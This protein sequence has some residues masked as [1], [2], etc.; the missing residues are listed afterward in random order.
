LESKGTTL[1]S[2][3]TA[4]PA[5]MILPK[6]PEFDQTSGIRSLIFLEMSK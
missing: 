4:F 6:L 5:I 3:E 2:I 1:A